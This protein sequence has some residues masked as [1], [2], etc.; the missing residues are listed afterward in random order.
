M[1]KTK[2]EWCA[3]VFFS[4]FF[5][6][7]L[8]RTNCVP[9]FHTNPRRYFSRSRANSRLPT[10]ER[11]MWQMVLD[12]TID[13]V[14]PFLSHRV[15]ARVENFS[16]AVFAGVGRLAQEIY[17]SVVAQRGEFA[18]K[19]LFVAHVQSGGTPFPLWLS[20]VLFRLFDT[21][22]W[23]VGDV[24]REVTALLK[25]RL[26]PKGFADAKGLF[27]GVTFDPAAALEERPGDADANDD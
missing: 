2:S 7:C 9:F 19:K 27:P 24:R 15:R 13:D 5:F 18:T 25:R 12:S 14:M 21:E 26:T 11:E 4:S 8:S 23:T 22:E 6:C 10:T 17:D 20:S 1:Y 3:R 16:E